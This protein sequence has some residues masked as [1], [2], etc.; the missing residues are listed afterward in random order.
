MARTITD[1]ATVQNRLNL[2][3]GNWRDMLSECGSHQIGF[4]PYRPLRA[5]N[6]L[7]RPPR[8]AFAA[9]VSGRAPA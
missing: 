9:D 1:I 8:S 7:G 5:W 4:I 2:T 3:S 6:D